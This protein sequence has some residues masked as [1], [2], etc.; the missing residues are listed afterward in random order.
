MSQELDIAI[1]AA[2]T[3]GNIIATNYQQ[4]ITTKYKANHQLVTDTDLASDQAIKSVISAQFPN[5]AFFSE[6]TGLSKNNSDFLWIIDPLDG[7]TNFAHHLGNFCVSIAL[8][9]KQSRQVGVV[10]N[11]LTQELFT[12]EKNQGAYL[13]NQPIQPAT[14]KN[15]N[16]AVIAISRGIYQRLTNAVRSYRVLG[17]TAL[18]LCYVACGRLDAQ[19]DHQLNYYDAAAGALIAAE[20]GATLTDFSNQ[21]WQPSLTHKSHLLCAPPQIHQQLIN[22]I[23]LNPHESPVTN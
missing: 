15:I 10:Y 11:P 13:N 18:S 19:A 6:E 5:H 20:A 7:T 14:T 2:Q 21:P 8:T 23:Q 16:N 3:A 4:P 1:T 12:A 22:V 17:S 9:Y